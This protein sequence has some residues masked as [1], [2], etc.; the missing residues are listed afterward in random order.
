MEFFNSLSAPFLLYGNI[1]NKFCDGLC[2]ETGLLM[3]YLVPYRPCVCVLNFVT[4]RYYWF[5]SC[6]SKL[7]SRVI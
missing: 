5:L 4:Y 7:D 3:V 6:H 1:L 2:M